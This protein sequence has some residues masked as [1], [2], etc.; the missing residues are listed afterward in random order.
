M[1]VLVGPRIDVF[2]HQDFMGKI[3]TH[4]RDMTMGMDFL[5]NRFSLALSSCATFV[6]PMYKICSE[7]P[8]GPVCTCS[9]S[10]VGTFCQYG[11]GKIL[12]FF[13]KQFQH[14]ELYSVDGFLDSRKVKAELQL[15]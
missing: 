2:V 5:N 13:E 6:C 10:K 7:Q 1:Q 15:K 14:C 4:V 11:K 9:G 3:V 8:S 12:Y